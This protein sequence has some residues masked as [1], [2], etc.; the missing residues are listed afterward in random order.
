MLIVCNLQSLV[1]I[2]LIN[3]I[4]NQK[5]STS[6]LDGISHVSDYHVKICTI[7]FRFETQNLTNNKKYML[8]SFFGGINFSTLSVK[9]ITPILS[10]FCIAENASVAAISATISRFKIDLEPKPRLS[11]TSK[12]GRAH[13]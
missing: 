1:I 8:P 3:K 2:I 5:R 13:V 4:R 10:L 7:A 11:D 12:I 6:F 9:N